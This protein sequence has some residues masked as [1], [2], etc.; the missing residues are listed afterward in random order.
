MG[1]GLQG[2]KVTGESAMH[3]ISIS[4][5]EFCIRDRAQICV[6]KLLQLE[7][8]E[9]HVE[10]VSISIIVK[11]MVEFSSDADSI[12]NKELFFY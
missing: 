8:D 4:L 11:A 9:I 2:K 5:W 10:K 7:N 6:V 3:K 12:Y 1:H